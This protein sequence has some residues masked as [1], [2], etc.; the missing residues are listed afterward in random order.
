[1]GRFAVVRRV[2]SIG[3]EILQISAGDERPRR[4]L[5]LNARLGA[6]ARGKRIMFS[7]TALDGSNQNAVLILPIRFQPGVRYPLITWV[8]PA[9]IFTDTLDK[10]ML[11]SVDDPDQAFLN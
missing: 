8:Y 4:L 2:S 1:H 7:Y 6:V 5:A 10:D 11:R 3:T 9:N